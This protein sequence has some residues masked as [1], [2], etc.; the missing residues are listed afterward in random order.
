MGS[1]QGG[2]TSSHSDQTVNNARQRERFLTAGLV[3]SFAAVMAYVLAFLFEFGYTTHFKILP[4]LITVSLT[5]VFISLLTLALG[6]TPVVQIVQPLIRFW[7][8]QDKRRLLVRIYSVLGF[9]LCLSIIVT[10]VAYAFEGV[11]MP[12]LQVWLSLPIIFIEASVALCLYL[13]AVL[14]LLLRKDKKRLKRKTNWSPG[15][16]IDD[17]MFWVSASKG[18]ATVL[19]LSILLMVSA[20]DIG[21]FYAA[22]FSK[23][24]LVVSRPREAVVLRVYGDNMILA[25]FDRSSKQTETEFFVLRLADTVDHP[26]RLENVG[27]L[28]PKPLET[29]Q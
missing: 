25:P 9:I 11:L 28:K 5:G 13:I 22:N 19:I 1:E 29:K 27:P 26:M 15:E 23:E 8:E 6:L 4:E 2:A 20:F 24:F 10:S 7:V 17:W 16:T 21:K 14:V 18:L 12:S 3:S